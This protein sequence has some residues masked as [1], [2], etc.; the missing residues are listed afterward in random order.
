M[1]YGI[2]YYLINGIAWYCIVLYCVVGFGAQAVSRKTPIYFKIL[3]TQTIWTNNRRYKYQE[4]A[5][6]KLPEKPVGKPSWRAA[7]NICAT[8]HQLPSME[9][10]VKV[11]KSLQRV[12]SWQKVAKS[13]Q[14]VDKELAKKLVRPTGL[15]LVIVAFTVIVALLVMYGMVSYDILWLHC[16][17]L[18]AFTML[19]SARGLCLARRLYTSWIFTWTGFCFWFFFLKYIGVLRDTARASKPTS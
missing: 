6:C 1:V 5:D 7:A 4:L 18:H 13:S 9:K 16:M 2:F 8:P 17:V 12:K 11:W 10:F 3:W 19:A 15:E 14:K